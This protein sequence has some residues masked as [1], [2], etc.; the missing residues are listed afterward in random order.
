MSFVVTPEQIRAAERR[1]VDAGAAEP[2][3]MRS[4]A[5]G[6]VDWIEDQFHSH[7]EERTAIGLVG[8]GNNG[9]DTLVALA[10]LSDLGWQTHACLIDRVEHGELP[11]DDALLKQ[12]QSSDRL[13]EAMSPGQVVVLDGIYGAG[14]RA[15]LSG[16]AVEINDAVRRLRAHHELAVIAIDLPSGVDA[17]TGAASDETLKA[18]VTLSL[19]A[20]K[21]GLMAEPAATLAGEV[22]HIDIGL[23]FENDNAVATII[24]AQDVSPR[25]PLRFATAGKHDYGGLLVVGGAPGYFGAPRLA[26]EAGLLTGAGIVGAAVPRMLVSTVAVQVPEVVFVPLSDSNARKSAD[27]ITKALTG[28]H[29]RY[30]AMVLGPGLGQD[31]TATSLLEHLFGQARAKT[32]AS[33]GFG[34]AQP[35]NEEPDEAG[36][37]A[38]GAVPVV[39]DADAL[40]WL[41]NQENRWSFLQHVTAVLTPHPGELARLRG[42]TVDEI[43]G[44]RVSAAIETARESGQVVVLKGGYTA[45]AS[46]DGRVHVAQRA[47]PELATPGTGDVLA[48][49]IGGFLAQGMDAFDAACAGVYVG[50]EAGRRARYATSSRSVLARDLLANIGG[51][52]DDLDG[53]LW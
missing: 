32:T 26:A 25:L 31:E 40:N 15:E 42:V 45:V 5:E 51:A 39:L 24:S 12:V 30:T 8:P 33:I 3:L 38:L 49:L 13:P 37:S 29:S 2:D 11:V 18:D 19:G 10:L 47:T 4:A 35:V 53:T 21:T 14:S 34:A 6:I 27:D 41:A 28:E 23:A 17:T 46:P 1:A 48:G 43:T 52:L 7:V 44:N 36:S 50:A 20:L 22:V 16:A 9:G